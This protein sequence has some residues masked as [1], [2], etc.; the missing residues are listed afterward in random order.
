MLAIIY[1]IIDL[2]SNMGTCRS[3]KEDINQCRCEKFKLIMRPWIP[4]IKMRLLTRESYIS[5]KER[6]LMDYND[7]AKVNKMFIE[8][9]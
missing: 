4:G 1:R 7:I 3:T 8:N 2:L 6:D 9:N 5:E